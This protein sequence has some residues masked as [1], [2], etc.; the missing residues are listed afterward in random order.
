MKFKGLS[1]YLRNRQN[2]RRLSRQVG[3]REVRRSLE[4]ERLDNRL[5]L[6]VLDF[7]DTIIDEIEPNDTSENAQVLPFGGD[8]SGVGINGAVSDTGD[9]DIFSWSGLEGTNIELR[10]DITAGG[11]DLDIT[12]AS[13]G[14]DNLAYFISNNSLWHQTT[15]GPNAAV[16]Q[17][18]SAATLA[19]AAGVDAGELVV[20]DL[21]T[22]P[23]GEVLVITPHDVS[24]LLVDT[25]GNATAVVTSAEIQAVTGEVTTAPLAI[26]ADGESNFYLAETIAGGVIKGVASG[27]GAETTFALEWYTTDT[28][29][30]EAIQR[31]V[32]EQIDEFR[33]TLPQTSLAETDGAFTA[34]SLVIGSGAFGPTGE[35]GQV[36]YTTQLGANYDGD[37]SITRIVANEDDPSSAVFTQFFAPGEGQEDLNPSALV[38]DTAGGAFGGKMYM[39]TFGPSLGDDQDGEIYVVEADGQ[40]SKLVI[41]SFI[42]MNDDPVE[43]DGEAVT[44]FFDITDMAFSYGG[45]FGDY[46]YVLSENIDQN[47]ET[48]G[49]FSSDLWRVSADGVAQLF[50]PDIADGVISLAFD[51]GGDYGNDLYVATFHGGGQLYRVD[52][53]GQSELFFDF[54]QFGGSLSIAD[55]VFAPTSDDFNLPL[56]NRLLVTLDAG[57]NGFIVQ[58]NP[59]GVDDYRDW[60]GIFDTGDVSS[61]DLAF[62][63]DGNLIIVEQ[64]SKGIT[65]ID[66]Q[67]VGQ[68]ELTGLELRMENNGGT[69]NYVPY[70]SVSSVEQPWIF[71]LSD[72]GD[73]ADTTAQVLATELN[74]EET[75]ENGNKNIRFDFD[76]DGDIYIFIQNAGT[77]QA[78]ELD[79]SEFS[80]FS[81]LLTATDVEDATDLI[82]VEVADLLWSGDGKLWA[83]AGN[84]T[85]AGEGEDPPSQNLDDMILVLTNTLTSGQDISEEVS[86]GSLVQLEV[87]LT[88][89]ELNETMIVTGGATL[90]RTF[91]D[92]VVG[93]YTLTIQSFANSIGTYET[94]VSLGGELEHTFIVTDGQ[95]QDIIMDTGDLVRLNYEGFGQAALEVLQTANGTVFDTIRL[96]VSGG[97]LASQVSFRNISNPG[98]LTLE[99]IVLGSSMGMLDVEGEVDTIRSLDE[100]TTG[101]VDETDLGTVKQVEAHWFRF[102]SF[103]A[104]SLGDASLTSKPFDVWSLGDLTIANDISNV[105][106]LH[107]SSRNFYGNIEVGGTILGSTFYGGRIGQLLVNNNEELEEGISASEFLLQDYGQIN[108]VEV[109]GDVANSEF[110]AGYILWQMRVLEGDLISTTLTS[111]LYTGTVYVEQDI[112]SG[113]TIE[114]GATYGPGINSV[115]CGGDFAGTIYASQVRS[116]KVGYDTLGNRRDE[117]EVGYSG[118]DYS[119]LVSAVLAV[120]EVNVTGTI[121]GGQITCSLGIITNVYAEDGIENIS[122]SAR[123]HI[124]R[125]MVGYLNGMRTAV[126]NNNA[127]VGGT[128]NAWMLGRIYYTGELDRDIS[129]PT[130]HGPLIDDRP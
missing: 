108:N 121:T 94:L 122:C 106:F 61:G 11:G 113:S 69:T 38:L 13:I 124:I 104:E 55:I 29:L 86:A 8:I 42:D 26:S 6:S 30:G 101:I 96:T 127:N 20:S 68:Y 85:E 105:T 39:G 56:E 3:T 116:L 46:L 47:G 83:L 22:L 33:V 18:A 35:E 115:G 15:V 58:I 119:G 95:S 92:I 111:S 1:N 87:I 90:E 98:T 67:S 88:G 7:A 24:V 117:T 31:D 103:T 73:T 81:D 27:N 79:G 72:S 36:F 60:G 16:S 2:S 50:V 48:P 40:I 120:G 19:A 112:R 44:G 43:M 49:G 129:L 64:A 14:P 65:R 4:V 10:M 71:R 97:N 28:I 77:F 123:W 32:L 57:E 74:T 89:G 76:A 126:I 63:A 52:S 107:G 93:D 62:D 21:A 110:D 109:H 37:G 54:S 25:E 114:V 128:Y 91:E 118:S 34:N 130:I 82:D 41:T 51:T 75:D 80:S 45:D 53:D 78:A 9:I 100:N 17:L 125:V 5:L 23:G 70:V 84:G 99:E 66:Y 102:L 59:A 12:A